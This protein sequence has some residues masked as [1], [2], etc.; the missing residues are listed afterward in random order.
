M[1]EAKALQV[2]VIGDSK[3]SEGAFQLAYEIGKLLAEL[4]ITTITGGRGGIMEAANKG[5]YDHGGQSIGILPSE[6]MED[7]N[8][9]CHIVFPTGLGHARK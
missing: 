4:N 3:T 7:A 6:H 1:Q 5:A 2:T 9:Y 8:P